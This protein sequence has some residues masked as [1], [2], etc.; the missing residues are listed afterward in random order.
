MVSL[1]SKIE[2]TPDFKLERLDN[3]DGELV[4]FACKNADGDTLILAD[5]QSCGKLW[6]V[7]KSMMTAW[8][9]MK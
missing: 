1:Q 7:E 8:F 3:K 5:Y 4:R 6:S 2:L 9:N